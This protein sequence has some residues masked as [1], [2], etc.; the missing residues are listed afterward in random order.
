MVKHE[1]AI[2]TIATDIQIFIFN[3]PISNL[4]AM[5]IYNK[6]AYIAHAMFTYRVASSIVFLTYFFCVVPESYSQTQ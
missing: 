6:I 3:F 1:L 2:N 4:L 5:I